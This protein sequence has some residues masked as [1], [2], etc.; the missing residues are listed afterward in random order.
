[1]AANVYVDIAV[2]VD[3]DMAIDL[4]A[5]M[6]VDL[7]MTW[8]LTTHIFMGQYQVVQIFLTY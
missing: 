5:N 7:Q 4:T 1:M 8:T 3:V 2:D 6:D